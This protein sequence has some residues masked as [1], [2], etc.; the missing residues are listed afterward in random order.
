MLAVKFPAGA[1]SLSIQKIA[2]LPRLDC[3][4]NATPQRGPWCHLLF[5]SVK[6]RASRRRPTAAPRS[7][8]LAQAGGRALLRSTVGTVW[9]VEEK[10]GPGLYSCF[11]C[12]QKARLPPT[13]LARRHDLFSCEMDN[14][15][16]VLPFTYNVF[17][18][19]L[20]MYVMVC[21]E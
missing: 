13:A 21:C 12:L 2:Q 16:E 11:P 9:L 20:Y 7:T 1:V 19:A 8:Q 4:V 14:W 6:R 18:I 17:E 3:L 10:F 15:L 5:L